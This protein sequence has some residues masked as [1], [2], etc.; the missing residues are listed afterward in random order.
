MHL[1]N[2][3][4]EEAQRTVSNGGYVLS[5]CPLPLSYISM[6]CRENPHRF[7]FEMSVILW[8]DRVVGEVPG[9]SK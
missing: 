7:P 3:A 2:C 4:R 9:A 1:L 5:I 6:M 8:I